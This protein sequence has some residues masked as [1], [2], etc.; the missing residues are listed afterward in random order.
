MFCKLLNAI[1]KHNIYTNLK[2]VLLNVIPLN[3]QQQV[4]SYKINEIIDYFVP[5]I[6]ERGLIS[7]RLRKH[8]ASFVYFDKFLI[9]LFVTTGSIFIALFATAT[10][11]PEGIPSACLSLVF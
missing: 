1:E 8:I 5:E 7:K 6:K 10:G 3:Y 11:A 2:S 4:M 9:V